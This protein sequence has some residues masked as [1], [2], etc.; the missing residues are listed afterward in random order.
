MAQVCDALVSLGHD[1]TLFAPHRQNTITTT[2]HAYYDAD[3]RVQLQYVPVADTIRW[4]WLPGPIGLW[5]LL[6][7]LRRRL[8]HEPTLR[9]ADLLYTR[10]PGLVSLLTRCGPPVILELH[11]PPGRWR[12]LWR[13]RLRHCH[14]IICLT[15]SLAQQL[16]A[17]GLPKA[18]LHVEGDGVSLE[19]F[20]N[21]PST[22]QART[23]FNLSP[24][25]LVVGYVGRLTTL[26]MDKGVS[27]LLTALASGPR[28]WHLLIV[29]GPAT[30]RE[31]YE[32]QAAELGLTAADV[33]FTGEVPARDV[34]RAMAACDILAMPFPDRPHF[35]HNMSPL[36]L[37]EYLAAGR[38]IL[39]SDLPTI[40][41]VLDE[42]TAVFCAPDNPASIQ[43][44]IAWIQQHPSDV[45][46]RM[47]QASTLVTHHTWQARMARVLQATI[48]PD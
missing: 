21:L 22:A 25:R 7:Q 41:E 8:R 32:R 33:T 46:A 42:R 48:T 34:P 10:S 39:S 38:I 37:F 35:R 23:A 13:K 5:L 1:V 36:K 2:Y 26:G 44:A 30:D 19:R 45:A 24:E 3:P 9:A 28:T 14:A 27:D 47:Q 17:W 4:R 40:R 20:Q 11:H 12:W 18:L 31:A 6:W 29:G 43:A 16:E 15:Q